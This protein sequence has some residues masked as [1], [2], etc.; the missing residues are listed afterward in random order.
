MRDRMN[1]SGQTE[2]AAGY[3][4]AVVVGKNSLG[5]YTKFADYN[6]SL[7]PERCVLYWWG[8]VG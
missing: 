1:A 8:R 4:Q 3:I 7:Y 6:L 2:M 5:A